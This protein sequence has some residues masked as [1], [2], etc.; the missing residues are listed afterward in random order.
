MQLKLI[1]NT[2]VLIASARRE[3]AALSEGGPSPRT[4]GSLGPTE[5][6]ASL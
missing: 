3:R 2:V 4:R 6:R 1:K 5:R